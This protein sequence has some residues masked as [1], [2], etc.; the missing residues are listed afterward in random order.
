MVF[1]EFAGVEDG[2]DGHV[3]GEFVAAG[4]HVFPD[5]TGGHVV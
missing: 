3:D 4:E 2:V 1:D 5:G